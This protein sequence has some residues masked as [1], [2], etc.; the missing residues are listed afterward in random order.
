MKPK[1]AEP[2]ASMLPRRLRAAIVLGMGAYF[3]LGPIWTQVLHRPGRTHQAWWRPMTWQ[4]YHSVGLNNCQGEFWAVRDGQRV[5]YTQSEIAE[6]LPR[7]Y[8]GGGK[9]NRW[10]PGRQVRAYDVVW[11]DANDVAAMAKLVCER[12]PDPAKADVRVYARC[13]PGEPGGRWRELQDGSKNMC[14]P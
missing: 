6:A 11:N 10:D 13:A 12:E 7:L 9:G 2:V 14:A 8:G 4:M 3:V 5:N 1:L